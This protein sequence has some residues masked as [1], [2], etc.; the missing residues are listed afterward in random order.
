MACRTHPSMD[1]PFLPLQRHPAQWHHLREATDPGKRRAASVAGVGSVARAEDGVPE[2]LHQEPPA[3]DAV[4][5]VGAAVGCV[6]DIPDEPACSTAV[7][8]DPET[9]VG[10]LRG[11]RWRVTGVP[12][13]HQRVG[14]QLRKLVPQHDHHPVHPGVAVRRPQHPLPAGAVLRRGERIRTPP[15]AL[16]AA[17]PDPRVRD[18]DPDHGR[19]CEV[20]EAAHGAAELLHLHVR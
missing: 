15:W 4:H 9:E 19:E 13:V 20:V 2:P 3:V 10:D 5:V 11:R 6:G 7:A 12:R 17:I 1:L 14:G 18:G 8:V 16:R